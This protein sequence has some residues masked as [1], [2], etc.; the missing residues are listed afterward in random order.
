MHQPRVHP[1]FTYF[2]AR[3]KNPGAHIYLEMTV[4]YV[5]K[6]QDYKNTMRTLFEANIW[7]TLHDSLQEYL[8]G[9]VH[10]FVESLST[11]NTSSTTFTEVVADTLC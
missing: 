2:A 11:V 7:Q 9:I 1:A 8:L 6:L 5:L 10:V 4:T 3:K